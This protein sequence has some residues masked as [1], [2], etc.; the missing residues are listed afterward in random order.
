MFFEQSSRDPLIDGVS[1]VEDEESDSGLIFLDCSFD[2]FEEELD[3][4][5][6]WILVHVV[7]DTQGDTEEIK[8][9]TFRGDWTIDFSLCVDVDLCDF[10][11][12]WL[13]LNLVSSDFGLLQV[14]DQLLIVQYRRWVGLWQLFQQWRLQLIQDNLELI[15]LL[16]QLLFLNLQLV[17]FNV[18]N[19]SQQL[20][21]QTR[22]RHNKVYDCTL[23][24]NFRSKVGVW[25]FGHQEQLELWIVINNFTTQLQWV[26][27]SFLDNSAWQQRIQSG[28]NFLLDTFQQYCTTFRDVFGQLPHPVFLVDVDWG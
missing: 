3:E 19:H 5:L 9:G 15:L 26:A 17:L 22:L 28:L 25:Q 4:T 10:G 1:D 20:L 23:S 13:L 21:F 8:H 14:V 7:D 6:E 18:H 2:S 12:L 27:T 24:S 11:D 16:D